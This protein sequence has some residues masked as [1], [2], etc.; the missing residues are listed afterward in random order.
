MF[1]WSILECSVLEKKNL[2]KPISGYFL[3]RAYIV[4]YSQCTVSNAC[5]DHFV[6]SSLFTLHLY[7][8]SSFKLTSFKTIFV[9]VAVG[10]SLSS[11]YHEIST[12]VDEESNLH[13]TMT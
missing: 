10:N 8:P 4:F 12:L 9:D 6:P 13:S 7:R 5:L 1:K 2:V 3:R 11:L